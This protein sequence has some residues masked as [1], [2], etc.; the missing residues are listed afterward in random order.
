[1]QTKFSDGSIGICGVLPRDAE[2]KQ[3]GK[4]NTDLCRFSVKVGERSTGGDK[5]EAV[6]CSCV[7]WGQLARDVQG[8]K[9][10]DT[11]FAVGKIQKEEYTA[12][13]GSQK[14]QTTLVCEAVFRGM[15]PMASVQE[16]PKP[17]PPETMTIPDSVD[18][19]T[20][21]GDLPF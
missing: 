9:K 15:L 10:L 14:E 19:Y 8:L 21:D 1:M 3:V 7:C 17:K 2:F 18:P 16:D 4:N 11:V 5:P 12:K 13:D 20:D 6:W